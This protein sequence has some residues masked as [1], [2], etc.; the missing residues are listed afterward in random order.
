MAKDSAGLSGAALSAAAR[1]QRA[2]LP[3][4]APL[5]EEV[6][7]AGWSS[8]RRMLSGNFH[9]WM[10]L[11]DGHLL[12]AVGR[13]VGAELGDPADAAL[14]AQAAWT[15]IRAHAHHTRDAGTLLSLAARTLWPLPEADQQAAVAVALV[16]AIGGRASVAVAG[17]CLVWRVRAATCEPLDEHQPAL[18]SS[19]H[20][21]YMAHEIELCLRERLLLVADHP[22]LRSERSVPSLPADFSRLSAESHRRMTAHDALSIV[23]PRYERAAETN[24]AAEASVVVLRRR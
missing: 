4:F 1:R 15:A 6:E 13:G 23:R 20:F 24:P 16:D 12:L 9:D 21:P 19:S 18:G 17:D 14:V 5:L 2:Q 22:Q 11:E 3:T 10:L 8:H 7:L